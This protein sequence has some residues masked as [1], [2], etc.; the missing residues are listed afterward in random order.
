MEFSHPVGFHF[1][2][3]APAQMRAYIAWQ[4]DERLNQWV[5]GWAPNTYTATSIVTRS[6]LVHEVEATRT[7]GYSRSNGGGGGSSR[8]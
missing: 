5:E 4:G 6:G 1:P 8:A 7:R 3:D 2:K